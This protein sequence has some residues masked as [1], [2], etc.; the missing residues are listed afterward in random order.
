MSIKLCR[1]D[2]L[3]FNPNKDC[4]GYNSLIPIGAIIMSYRKRQ[5]IIND[6]CNEIKKKIPKKY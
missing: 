4:L 2:S 6:M 1:T 5:D 3:M